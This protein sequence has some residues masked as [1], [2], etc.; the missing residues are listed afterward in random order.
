MT[1]FLDLLQWPAMALTVAAAYLVASSKKRR[2]N[3]GFWLFLASNVLWVAWG[4]PASTYAVV[5]LQV[6]LAAL[7]LR[8]LFKT[9]ASQDAAQPCVDSAPK[10]HGMMSHREPRERPS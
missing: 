3:I 9:H 2:R 4:I 8:G 7:N 5:T 6:F 1:V 10:A